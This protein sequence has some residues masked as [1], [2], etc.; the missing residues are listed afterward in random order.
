[1]YKYIKKNNY[2]KCRIENRSIFNWCRLKFETGVD[3][4]T[5]RLFEIYPKR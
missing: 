1:M 4:Y 5:D 2:K 3:E